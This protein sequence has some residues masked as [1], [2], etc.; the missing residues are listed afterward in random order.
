MNQNIFEGKLIVTM[1]GNTLRQGDFHPIT[2]GQDWERLF[3]IADYHRVAGLIY[4][5][6]L[7]SPI[8]LPDSWRS[9]FFDRYQDALRHTSSYENEESEILNLLNRR[10]VKATILGSSYIKKLYAIPETAGITALRLLLDDNSYAVAKGFLIDMGYS[11]EKSFR[12]AGD[13]LISENGFEVELYYEVPFVTKNYQR[14]MTKVLNDAYVIEDMPNIKRLIREGTYAFMAAEMVWKYCTD[15]LNFRCMMDVWLFE[16]A[17]RRE[18][19]QRIVAQYLHQFR[20][21]DVVNRLLTISSMWFG[22]N[23]E[24]EMSE[25]DLI[26]FDAMEKRIFTSGVDGQEKIAEAA[27]IRREIERY[28]NMEE[29]VERSSA[30]RHWFHDMAVA[31]MDMIYWVVPPYQEMC[32]IYPKLEQMPYLL[33]G[34]WVLR[35]LQ[36]LFPSL[37]KSKKKNEEKPAEGILKPETKSAPENTEKPQ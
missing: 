19:N 37:K 30:I 27:E 22:R 36:M 6:L 32:L 11:L 31:L 3:R 7:G 2:Q 14:A 28:L 17:Y 12:G 21:E 8:E 5:F 1:V 20:I 35:G 9:K 26:I 16:Q 25:S 24:S 18:M 34:A 29:E 15:E 23:R 10:G 4:L 13:R 33:P